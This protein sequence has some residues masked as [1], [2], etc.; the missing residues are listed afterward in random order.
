LIRRCNEISAVFCW[1]PRDCPAFEC[2]A[3]GNGV[4]EQLP[5]KAPT[6]L[7]EIPEFQGPKCGVDM[8]A[9]EQKLDEVLEEIE[10]CLRQLRRPA[11]HAPVG[12]IHGCVKSRLID[13]L[14]RTQSRPVIAALN[15]IP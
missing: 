2:L 6:L 9:A 5:G 12:E 11:E 4:V 14:V 10:I 8:F 13:V 7:R 3:L 15:V 1:C